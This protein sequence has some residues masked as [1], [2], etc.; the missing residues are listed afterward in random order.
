ME[1]II[2]SILILNKLEKN[3]SLSLKEHAIFVIYVHI[4]FK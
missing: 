4:I 1:Q 3:Q 2:A